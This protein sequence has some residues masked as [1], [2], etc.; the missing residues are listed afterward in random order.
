MRVSP[1]RLGYWVSLGL[2]QALEGVQGLR[3]A[4]VIG[5]IDECDSEVLLVPSDR[6]L[7]HFLDGLQAWPDA[8]RLAEAWALVAT[9]RVGTPEHDRAWSTIEALGRPILSGS[10]LGS[11]SQGPNI[12]Y[13]LR[14]YLWRESSVSCSGRYFLLLPGGWHARLPSFDLSLLCAISE[15][16]KG[17]LPLHAAAVRTEDGVVLLAGPSGAGKSTAARL[18]ATRGGFV[19]HDDQVLL[20]Q[21]GGT[22]GVRAWGTGTLEPTSPLLGVFHLLKGQRA[23]LLSLKSAQ[24][25]SLLLERHFDIV[26]Q[27]LDAELLRVAVDL[28]G[29]LVRSVPVRRLTFSLSSEFWDLLKPEPPVGIRSK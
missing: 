23:S 22:W 7:H 28:V 18:G 13:K 9:S 27:I 14:P 24:A 10:K 17:N 2:R 20:Q 26:G 1:E 12:N 29:R 5:R 3:L 6:S 19:L 16:G 4:E 11:S 25:A 8:P 15:L 21:C